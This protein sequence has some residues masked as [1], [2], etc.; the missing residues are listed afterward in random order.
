[1]T[2]DELTKALD[3]ANAEIDALQTR[4]SQLE[5]REQQHHLPDTMILSENFT[6]RSLAVCGHA[7]AGGI[8]ILVLPWALYI[9]VYIILDSLLSR[10]FPIG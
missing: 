7:I 6:K 8:L 10:P 4:L 5:K 3:K 9:I 2:N 1:M